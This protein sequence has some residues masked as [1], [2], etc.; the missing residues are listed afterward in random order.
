MEVVVVVE[1]AV[2]G[3]S[4]EGFLLLLLLSPLSKLEIAALWSLKLDFDKYILVLN[5]SIQMFSLLFYDVATFQ[6]CTL[7]T[8]TF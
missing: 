3:D 8:L 5:H 1:V 2:V 6:A 4:D 7:H